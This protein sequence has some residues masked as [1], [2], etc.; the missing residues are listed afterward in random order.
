MCRDAKRRGAKLS[1]ER[2]IFDKSHERLGRVASRAT[3]PEIAL[4]SP[5]GVVTHVLTK[6]FSS[7]M[8]MCDSRVRSE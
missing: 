6:F 8:K 1:R 4:G 7:R 5:S 2:T 3:P